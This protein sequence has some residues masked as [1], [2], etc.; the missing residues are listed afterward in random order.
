MRHC[1]TSANSEIIVKDVGSVCI[2][3]CNINIRT[4]RVVQHEWFDLSSQKRRVVFNGWDYF[5]L[6]LAG[7]ETHPPVCVSTNKVSASLNITIAAHQELFPV[8]PHQKRSSWYS[9]LL[10]CVFTKIVYECSAIRVRS[11]CMIIYS[12]QPFVR[13]SLGIMQ[14]DMNLGPCLPTLKCRIEPY[15]LDNLVNKYF[16]YGTQ[17]DFKTVNGKQYLLKVRSLSF[18]VTSCC[19]LP[20]D[21]ISALC[22]FHRRGSKNSKRLNRIFGPGSCFIDKDQILVFDIWKPNIGSSKLHLGC[23]SEGCSQKTLCNYGLLLC[24]KSCFMIPHFKIW[25][26]IHT[27]M[28]TCCGLSEIN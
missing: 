12:P 25:T 27:Y 9:Y 7:S 24:N 5:I 11:H 13:M 22:V 19:A 18:F 14:T 8:L 3:E 15:T 2:W 23:R 28:H 20:K 26:D 4:Y 10:R 21:L 1:S 17:H 6:A 16:C